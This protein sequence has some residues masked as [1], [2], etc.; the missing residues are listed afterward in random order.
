MIVLGIDPGEKQSGYC[1]W[2]GAKILAFGKVDN[3][4]ISLLALDIEGQPIEIVGIEMISS[5][6]ISAGQETFETCRWEGRMEAHFESSVETQRVR[7]RDVKSHLCE[8]PTAKDKDV[9]EALINR[10]GPIGTKKEP[11]PC[12]KITADVWSALSVAVYV[13]DKENK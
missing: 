13:W 1:Y 9:R 7:R 8:N 2:D 5:Y 12:Y 11:G 3:I 6:G 10:I 4:L